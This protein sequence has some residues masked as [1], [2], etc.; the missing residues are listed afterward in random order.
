M[1]RPLDGTLRIVSTTRKLVPLALLLIAVPLAANGTEPEEI[2][3]TG[4]ASS[5][6]EARRQAAEFVDSVGVA[7]GQTPAARWIDP[8]CPRVFGLDAVRRAE[9]EQRLRAHA[10]GVGAKLGKPGCTANL[11][12]IFTA[13][14]GSMVKKIAGRS[15]ETLGELAPADRAA[16]VASDAPVR[17]WYDTEARGKDG[18][19][20]I[21]M[22]FLAG[23]T[24]EGGAPLV[25][26]GDTFLQYRSS[27]VST[28]SVRSIRAA[29]IIVDV[30]RA[31]GVPLAAVG[32]YAAMVGL[33]EVRRPDAAP[34]GSILALFESPQPV[35]AITERDSA[36]LRGLYAMPLDRLARQHRQMLVGRMTKPKD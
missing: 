14:A 9:I 7:A 5:P 20:E 8:V 19:R 17:W 34:P 11:A 10:A 25:P 27:L 22:P 2:V 3:V 35:R 18:Q 33:A 21:G 6:A 15:T 29:T 28:L 26:G 16:L 24:D 31:S 32:D 4:T 1:I 12:V 36:F 13:D 23:G 30:E